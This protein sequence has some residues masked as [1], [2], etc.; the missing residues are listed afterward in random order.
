MKN[1]CALL[2]VV[3]VGRAAIGCSDD[4][5]FTPPDSPDNT[6]VVACDDKLGCDAG[7]D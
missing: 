1:I 2:L 3:L 4:G 6:A 5:V 7:T